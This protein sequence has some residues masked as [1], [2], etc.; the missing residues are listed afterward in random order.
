MAFFRRIYQGESCKNRFLNRRD[1]RRR[2][3]FYGGRARPFFCPR[4]LFLGDGFFLFL[5]RGVRLF[6]SF[7]R[8]KIRGISWGGKG[9]FFLSFSRGIF[10]LFSLVLSVCNLHVGRRSRPLPQGG[11]LPW[12]CAFISA[13]ARLSKGSVGDE[14]AIL[15]LRACRRD[16]YPRKRRGRMCCFSCAFLA[17][18]RNLDGAPICGL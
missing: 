5:A 8:R 18:R 2:G 9:A 7:P 11:A 17:R 13:C 15:F 14:L 4:G 1:N 12:V 6:F 3:L 16:F 10:S